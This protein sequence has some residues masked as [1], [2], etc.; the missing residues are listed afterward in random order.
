MTATDEAQIRAKL[1][2]IDERWWGVH[3]SHDLATGRV[4][5]GSAH[6]HAGEDIGYLSETVKAR[7]ALVKTPAESARLAALAA[8]DEAQAIAVQ[9]V[10]HWQADRENHDLR[11]AMIHTGRAERRA[12]AALLD[13][14]R[15]GATDDN[16]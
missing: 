7:L 8:W 3:T 10:A 6:R 5:Y 14:Q 9:A 1:S 13:A 15:K 2:E 11:Q 12:R 16:G 4:G